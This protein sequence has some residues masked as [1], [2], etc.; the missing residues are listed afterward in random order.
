MY[1]A[2]HH[3]RD[4]DVDYYYDFNF[5]PS[6]ENCVEKPEQQS[7]DHLHAVPFENAEMNLEA[8][9]K[10]ASRLKDAEKRVEELEEDKKNLLKQMTE[11]YDGK[12]K[13]RGAYENLVEIV[14]EKIAKD[15]HQCDEPLE[16]IIKE[17]KNKTG[18]SINEQI[19]EQKE[20]QIKLPELSLEFHEEAYEMMT[21]GDY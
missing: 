14:L 15:C 18:Y 10:I 11:Y 17:I 9:A 1:K 5:L 20:Y 7:I 3:N 21:N 2:I 8:M 13:W 19:A 16:A 12:E 6:L 4:Y